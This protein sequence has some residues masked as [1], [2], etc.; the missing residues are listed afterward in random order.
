MQRA[1]KSATRQ[2]A[3]LQ[4][5]LA[6]SAELEAQVGDLR[7]FVEVLL[8]AAPESRPVAE[9]QTERAR[10]MRDLEARLMGSIACHRAR[11][12][13]GIP[14]F[15]VSSGLDNWRRANNA[16]VQTCC[17]CGKS[18]VRVTRFMF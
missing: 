14:C 17:R 3:R 1:A 8:A 5:L 16:H 6:T 12:R 7:L 15:V 11:A 18:H 13:V 4:E 10:L 2:E 9:Q